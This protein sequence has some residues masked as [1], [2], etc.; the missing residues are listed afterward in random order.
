MTPSELLALLHARSITLALAGDRLA[1][2]PK[3]AVTPELRAAITEH[4]AALLGMLRTPRPR[5][6]FGCGST[7]FWWRA[8]LCNDGRTVGNW[9]CA[10]CHPD[11]ASIP[12]GKE[13]DGEA[14][15]PIPES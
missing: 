5:R 13:S 14:T 10:T 6:C 11:P 8:V 9:L 2:T 3:S 4:K 12:C 15:E 1:A 7:T